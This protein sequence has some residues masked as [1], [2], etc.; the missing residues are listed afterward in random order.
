MSAKIHLVDSKY[1]PEEAEQ[2]VNRD[3]GRI[4]TECGIFVPASRAKTVT[5]DR[6]RATCKHCLRSRGWNKR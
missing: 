3:W 1:T 5:I 4:F 2:V 6:T